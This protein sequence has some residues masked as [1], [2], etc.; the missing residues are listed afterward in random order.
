MLPFFD[1]S[2]E[3]NPAPAQSAHAL[4]ACN[5]PIDNAIGSRLRSALHDTSH[6]IRVP[7]RKGP[8]H[9]VDDALSHVRTI[10]WA[11]L[12]IGTVSDPND[13]DRWA[14]NR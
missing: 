1:E 8:S 2:V 14:I 7:S 10:P 12:I 11:T 4:P 13:S 6:K 5:L 3:Q 9:D